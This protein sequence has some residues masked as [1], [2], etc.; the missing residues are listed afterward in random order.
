[1]YFHILFFFSS[2][3][4]H[5]RLQG[6][7]SSD[8]CSSDLCCPETPRVPELGYRVCRQRRGITSRV[9]ERLIRKRTEWKQ[10]QRAA[11]AERA[12]DYKLRRDAL[13]W[14][15]VCCF[16]YTGYKNAR[17]GQIEAPQAINAL[18]RGTPLGAKQ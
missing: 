18:A 8:V 11:P 5:T 1:M 3:R 6:D 2:R 14:L 7:W 17:F 10:L 16:G 15:L 13:K 12:R 9:G 4:R